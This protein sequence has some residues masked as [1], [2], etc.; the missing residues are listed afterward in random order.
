MKW[1][2]RWA[3]WG[4]LRIMIVADIVFAIWF[5]YAPSDLSG[6]DLTLAALVAVGLNALMIS[7]AIMMYRI[8]RKF[9]AESREK[10]P[11][12]KPTETE[13]EERAMRN[14]PTPGTR[15]QGK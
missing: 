3:I 5:K 11:D 6:G 2:E 12:G 8:A 1:L 15:Y 4:M 10:F 13:L 9:Y 7:L 14:T